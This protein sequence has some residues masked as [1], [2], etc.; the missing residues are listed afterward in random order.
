M[1]EVDANENV[2]E[3]KKKD[4]FVL[5]HLDTD[6]G[7]MID[8]LEKDKVNTLESK[9]NIIA[10]QIDV[11]RKE[12]LKTKGVTF[13]AKSKKEKQD[14]KDSYNDNDWQ[15]DTY[16]PIYKTVKCGNKLIQKCCNI[17]GG[18]L[19]YHRKPNTIFEN[20]E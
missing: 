2:H 5:L 19:P 9:K 7:M 14:I 15:L 8:G 1:T 20:R 4:K 12:K 17:P 6:K 10:S 18:M 16:E 11:K 3:K 13:K